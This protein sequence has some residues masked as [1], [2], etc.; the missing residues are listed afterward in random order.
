MATLNESRDFLAELVSAA[1]ANDVNQICRVFQDWEDAG[2]TS[3]PRGSHRDPLIHFT[4]ALNEALRLGNL[5]T[6]DAFFR[7]GLPPDM[8][9]FGG[10]SYIQTIVHLASSTHAIT[11]S[12]LTTNFLGSWGALVEGTT[13][14][15]NW[16]IKTFDFLISRGWDVNYF[17]GHMG[18][19]LG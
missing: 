10:Q 17:W 11:R 14:A 18:D 3:P 19:M 13:E 5:E 1:A 9:H 6:L 2:A 16:N 7:R 8:E 12:S 15:N 4:P